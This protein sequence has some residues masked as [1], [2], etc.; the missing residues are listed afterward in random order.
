M[1]L[2]RIRRMEVS[3][4]RKTSPLVASFAMCSLITA[5]YGVYVCVVLKQVEFRSQLLLHVITHAI[6]FQCWIHSV[7]SLLSDLQMLLLEQASS[8]RPI[9][10]CT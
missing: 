1:Y 10:V 2:S 9:E 7:A 3:G 4:W 5:T 6:F 8:H